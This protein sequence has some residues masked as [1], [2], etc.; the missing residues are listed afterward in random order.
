[1]YK[2]TVGMPTF[3]DYDGVY[4]SISA[5]RLYHS[6]LLGEIEFLV[7]D[8]NPNGR[9]A[10]MTKKFV[11]SIKGTYIPFG[12][13]TST[14]VGKDLIFKYA[15][16]PYVVCI[17]S[18]VLI[19]PGAL[20]KLLGYFEQNRDC[21]DLLQGPLQNNNLSVSTHFAPDWRG[22]MWGIW[23]ADDRGKDPSS[24]PFEI[25]MQ[26]TGLMACRKDAWL[27]FNDLFRGFGGQ[28][29]YI[30][31]KYRKAG[32]KTLCLPFLRWMHRFG[33][34]GSAKYQV[35]VVDKFRNYVIGFR[36]LNLDVEPVLAHFAPALKEN[37]MKEIISEVDKEM[38]SGP[39]VACLMMTYNRLPLGSRLLNEAIY[40]F[41]QQTYKK[42]ELIIINDCPGQIINYDHPDVVVVN[43]SRRFGSLGEKFNLAASLTKADLLCIWDDDDVYLPWRLTM[44]VERLGTTRF[45]Q[46]DAHWIMN[47]GQL[48]Y[49]DRKGQLPA[50][51]IFTHELFD[52]VGGF[53]EVS[54][55]INRDLQLRMLAA[56]SGNSK[57]ETISREKCAY[58]YRFKGTGSYHH[59]A[60]PDKYEQVGT[61]EIEECIFMPEPFWSQDYVELVKNARQ[62]AEKAPG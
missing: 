1:M 34:P 17:D 26:G 51:G 10:Q 44:A 35:S 62:T 21:K 8:N 5:I 56:T 53:R 22:Q 20:V 36:E 48:T 23:S 58:V 14:S 60:S 59:S 15:T 30:H 55:D 19:A 29:G 37:K 7:V 25:P 42:K 16:A 54:H 38:V 47:D 32:R 52:E 2:L 61:L 18:H 13:W 57:R 43:I 46:P 31:E 24:A 6:E 4:F 33:H 12:K 49:I 41:H 40:S 27:G 28:A 39:L 50:K 11:E 45:W 9:Y 3:D